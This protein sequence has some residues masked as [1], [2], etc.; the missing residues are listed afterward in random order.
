MRNFRAMFSIWLMKVA[1]KVYSPQMMLR[2][3]EKQMSKVTKDR[4]FMEKIMMGKLQEQKR[5][6][7]YDTN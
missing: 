1:L 2:D 7:K 5:T 4:K 6:G 3:M